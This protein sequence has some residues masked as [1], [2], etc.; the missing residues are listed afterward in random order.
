MAE[1]RENTENRNNPFSFKTFVKSKQETKGPKKK[2]QEQQTT[3]KCS[4]LTQRKE[5]ISVDESPFPEVNKPGKLKLIGIT[6]AAVTR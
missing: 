4:P 6:K 5:E 2:K 1:A 3:S